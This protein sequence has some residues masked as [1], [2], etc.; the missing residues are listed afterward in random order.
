MRDPH[1]RRRPLQKRKNVSR[2]ISFEFHE[3][4]SLLTG[5]WDRLK[6]LYNTRTVSWNAERLNDGSVDSINDLCW[7]WLTDNG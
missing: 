4:K 1:Y 7:L 2:G 3:M 6:R 5:Q